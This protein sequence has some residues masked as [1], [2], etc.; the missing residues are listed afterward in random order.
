MQGELLSF[1]EYQF[2]ICIISSRNLRHFTAWNVSNYPVVCVK[3][4]GEMMQM[5]RWGDFSHLILP[6]WRQENGARN[7]SW[8][9]SEWLI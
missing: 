7:V 8:R 9:L 5:M 2:M 3:S 6:W 1:Q 4:L